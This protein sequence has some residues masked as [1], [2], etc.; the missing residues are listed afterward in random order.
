MMNGKLLAIFVT[1]PIVVVA[2]ILA[3]KF[4]LPSG[5]IATIVGILAFFIYLIYN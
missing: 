4:K 2:A 3:V 5:A 1:I